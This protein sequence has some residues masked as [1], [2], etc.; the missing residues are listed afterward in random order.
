MSPRSRGPVATALKAVT[1]DQC[2]RAADAACGARS[3]AD[4]R[5]AAGGAAPG[6]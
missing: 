2:R 4:A 6:D 3:A 1:L 5:A